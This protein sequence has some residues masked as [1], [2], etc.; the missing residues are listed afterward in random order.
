MWPSSSMRPP[1]LREPNSS[2]NITG[3]ASEKKAENGLR[4]NSLFWARNWRQSRA[5]SDGRPSAGRSD[6][7]RLL[8]AGQ[9]EVDVLQGGPGHGQG[10]Q[11]LAPGQGPGGEDVQGPGRLGGAQLDPVLVRGRQ[12]GQVGRQVGHGR[13]RRQ[14]DGELRL[15]PVAAAARVGGAG[16]PPPARG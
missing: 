4:R 16:G 11:L 15:A 14:A 6:T 7:D 8:V 2:R 9:P 5:G 3:K 13:A 10:L 12:T 1:P